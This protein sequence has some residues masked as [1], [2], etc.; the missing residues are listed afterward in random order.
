MEVEEE[1]GGG[2]Y[3]IPIQG[4]PKVTSYSLYNWGYKL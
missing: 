1:G 2:T 4:G 3:I